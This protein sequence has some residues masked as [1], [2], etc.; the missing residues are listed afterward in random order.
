MLSMQPTNN[1]TNTGSHSIVIY[2]DKISTIEY[3]KKSHNITYVE[4]GFAKKELLIDQLKTVI[5][6]SKT[7]SVSSVIA[8][9]RKLQG[10]FKNIFSYLNEEYYP[11]LKSQGLKCK[12][13]IVSED[14]ISNHLTNELVKDLKKLG[15]NAAIFSTTKSAGNW[16]RECKN[17]RN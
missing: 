13:F 2:R 9:F 3:D 6:F 12:A 11:A 15:I 16:V 14:I 7:Y 8:D 10:S 4:H 5:E 1:P 17:E